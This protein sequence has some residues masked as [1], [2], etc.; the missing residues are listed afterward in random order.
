MMM[1]GMVMLSG[2]DAVTVDANGVTVLI[3][4]AVATM[5]AH[6]G[7]DGVDAAVAV[8]TAVRWTLAMTGA[9]MTARTLTIPTLPTTEAL[10]T[11]MRTT[12]LGRTRRCAEVM[13]QMPIA[14]PDI[15]LEAVP[16][17][18]SAARL[19]EV[20]MMVTETGTMGIRDIDVVMMCVM[21]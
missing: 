11:I 15:R 17:D 13:R 21:R 19:G 5:T 12:G 14:E 18:V 7:I 16:M 6:D 1:A 20:P 3:R 2:H 10:V 9:D 8:P 4:A